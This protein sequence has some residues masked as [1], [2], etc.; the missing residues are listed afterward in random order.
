MAAHAE[1]LLPRLQRLLGQA[2]ADS[3]EDAALLKRFVSRRDETAFAAL[4]ARHG[5]MVLGVCRRI[6]RDDHTVMEI[7]CRPELSSA[8]GRYAFGTVI[9]S[10]G[11]PS[12]RMG[13]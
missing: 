6:L 4:L 7:H 1:P 11:S 10:V 12:R 5:P 13:S 2:N 8:W 9:V 3:C